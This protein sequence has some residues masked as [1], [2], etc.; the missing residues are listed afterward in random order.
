MNKICI[1]Y[2]V[3]YMYNLNSFLSTPGTVLTLQVVLC[4]FF[5]N[6]FLKAL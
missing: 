6:A 3:F 5:F 1:T 4:F 2:S